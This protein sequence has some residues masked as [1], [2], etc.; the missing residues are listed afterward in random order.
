ME[1][2]KTRDL[3]EMP[4]DGRFYVTR[5]DGEEVAELCHATGVEVYDGSQWWNEYYS[6][7][8]RTYLYGR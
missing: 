1:I 4:L 5:D 2:L 3:K 6:T 7:I 8:E